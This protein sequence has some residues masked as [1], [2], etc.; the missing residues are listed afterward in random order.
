MNN[1]LKRLKKTLMKKVAK[2]KSKP[3]HKTVNRKTQK[4]YNFEICIFSLV[5]VQLFNYG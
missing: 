4:N 2:K 3:N 1:K 5:L